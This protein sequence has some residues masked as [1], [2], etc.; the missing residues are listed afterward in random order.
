MGRKIEYLTQCHSTSEELALRIKNST[1]EEG[2]IVVAGFQTGGKG[3]RG[4]TWDSEANKNLLFSLYLKPTFLSLDDLY[5]INVLVS[6]ALQEAVLALIPKSS[7]EVKWPNDLYV[8]NRKIAGVLVESSIVQSEVRHL[9]VGIGL[10]VNQIEFSTES[11]TSLGLQTGQEYDLP[12]V[13]ELVTL[14]IEEKYLQL[15]S[16]GVQ[17]LIFDYHQAM[18]WRGELHIFETKEGNLSGEII[19]INNKGMLMLKH[20][21]ELRSYGIKEI[22]F[23]S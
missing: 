10:N 12:S 1:L 8:D 3:Q 4:N 2:Y 22:K 18:R 14:K 19:G 15:N 23:I 6:V 13:L 16:G 7:V 5:I 11:V 17:R 21:A 9:I 20:N